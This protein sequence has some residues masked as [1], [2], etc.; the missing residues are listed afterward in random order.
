MEERVRFFMEECD[1][2]Q[3]FQ[4]FTDIHDG[5]GGFT[6]MLQ[7]ALQDE[8]SKK[9]ILTLALSPRQHSV[10]ENERVLVNEALALKEFA[11]T[12]SLCVPLYLP[13]LSPSKPPNWSKYLNTTVSLDALCFL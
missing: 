1:S 10:K 5:F 8:Y 7:Q 9:S 12:S 11:L 2:P 3:G 4:I 13:D 6:S